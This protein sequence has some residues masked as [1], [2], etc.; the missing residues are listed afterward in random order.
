LIKDKPVCFVGVVVV[1]V[2]IL[3]NSAPPEASSHAI[4]LVS[5]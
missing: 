3:K 1:A 2:E 5:A 4:P